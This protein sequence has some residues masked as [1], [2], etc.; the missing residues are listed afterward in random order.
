MDNENIT[1]TALVK[2]EKVIEGRLQGM[3]KQQARLHAGYSESVAKTN[4][5]EK[6]KAYAYAVERILGNN[7]ES[8]HLLSDEIQARLTD[9]DVLSKLNVQ[10]IAQLHKVLA[11]IHKIMTPQVTIKE[12]QMKDGTTKRT[13]WGQG[14]VQGN[15]IEA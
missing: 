8:M 13:V 14:S 7:K 15:E 2:A 12:E 9:T 6:T 1:K 10:E 11:D 4:L 5:P 3:N